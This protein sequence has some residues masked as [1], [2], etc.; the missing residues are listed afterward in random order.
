MCR[1][2]PWEV[3][4]Q[5]E[6]DRVEAITLALWLISVVYLAWGVFEFHFFP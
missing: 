4:L 1:A 6:S 3:L 2:E 5:R